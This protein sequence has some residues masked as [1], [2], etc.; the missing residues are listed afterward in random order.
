MK[1]PNKAYDV[2][3]DMRDGEVSFFRRKYQ[4]E[5]AEPEVIK[6]PRWLLLEI[7]IKVDQAFKEGK[8]TIQ[9]ELKAVIGVD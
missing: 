3:L 5:D 8:E 4:A 2:E 1:I 9:T 7:K 6:L